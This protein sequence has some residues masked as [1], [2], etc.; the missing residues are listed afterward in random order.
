M[1]KQVSANTDEEHVKRDRLDTSSSSSVD[2][3]AL[4]PKRQPKKRLKLSENEVYSITKR[5][6][7]QQDCSD[8]ACKGNQY[9]TMYMMKQGKRWEGGLKYVAIK[10]HATY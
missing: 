3:D 9:C 6:T 10:N 2:G 5:C 4:S 8:H 1:V 7:L